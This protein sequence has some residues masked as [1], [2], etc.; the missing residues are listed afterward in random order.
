MFIYILAKM[1][2]ITPCPENAWLYPEYFFHT[3]LEALDNQQNNQIVVRMELGQRGWCI[4]T[5]EDGVVTW[6]PSHTIYCHA[7][8]WHLEVEK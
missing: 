8:S 5:E 1:L 3:L 6:I 2:S 7:E 4:Y